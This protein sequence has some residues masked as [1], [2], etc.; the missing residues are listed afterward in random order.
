M[1]KK[2]V[3]LYL[4]ADGVNVYMENP[5]ESTRKNYRTYMGNLARSWI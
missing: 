5:N 1:G 3:K 4:F 2:E